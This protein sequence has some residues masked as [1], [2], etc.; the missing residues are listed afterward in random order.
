MTAGDVPATARADYWRAVARADRP[1]AVRIALAQ[2]DAGSG[3]ADVL[4]DLVCSV[5]L[6]VGRRWAAGEWNVAR[7]HAATSIGEDV[8]AA[9]TV[10]E[11][12]SPGAS[13]GTVVVACVEGEWHSLPARVLAETLRIG[14]W[15]VHN[16]GASVPAAHLLQFVHDIG[17]D[18][19]A[20]SCSVSTSLPRA[21]RMIEASR[22]AGV[23]VIAGGRGFGTDGRW[24]LQLGANAW[25]PSATAALDVLDGAG[26][27][28]FTG[29]APHFD[30]PDDSSGRLTAALPGRVAEAMA[31][32]PSRL[33]F[34]AAYTA[35]QLARTREDVGHI[36]SF[37]AVSLYLDDAGLFE[38]FAD[39]LAD[40]LL[41]RGVPLPAVE[42]SLEVVAEVVADLPRAA[43]VVAAGRAALT[44]RARAS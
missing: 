32:L 31:M 1:A 11:P 10:R 3:V 19:T 12:S 39:W 16:L 9:L 30:S 23:P 24:A 27:P 29:P 18:A 36:L 43:P 6:E 41:P 8:V 26:W 2:L 7:E 20:L 25:A 34:M 5:Q 15:R 40:I 37:L 35:D 13:R 44:R 22:E 38:E 21:R 33:P 17:P 4:R 42:A 14:G 28:A